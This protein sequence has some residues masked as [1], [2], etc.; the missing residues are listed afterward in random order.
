[1]RG[2]FFLEM[3]GTVRV[4]TKNFKNMAITKVRP[5]IHSH[6]FTFL[7]YPRNI[8]GIS[9][10]LANA[11]KGVY[12]QKHVNRLAEIFPLTP[13]GGVEPNKEGRA[14]EKITF[15]ITPDYEWAH[16]PSLTKAEIYFLHRAKT[17]LE[18]MDPMI[19]EFVDRMSD[20]SGVDLHPKFHPADL[21]PTIRT[22][23]YFPTNNQLLA[24]A[25]IDKGPATIHLYDSLPGLQCLWGG[26]WK[27]MHFDTNHAAAFPGGIVQYYTE[28]AIKALWHRVI[29]TKK[30]QKV[31]RDSIVLFLD[32]KAEDRI[33]YNKCDFGSAQDAFGKPGDTYLMRFDEYAKFFELYDPKREHLHL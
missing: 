21:R 14:D 5:S 25:H 4:N 9:L 8:R 26:K 3:C 33:I 11:W 1:M 6:G 10:D 19:K 16:I 23:H 2:V 31:G 18:C 7:K 20:A 24:K 27:S 28:C 30:T 17:M 29:A 12:L 15:H 13:Q 22:L 32:S